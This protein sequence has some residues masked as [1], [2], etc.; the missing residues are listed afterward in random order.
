M[1]FTRPK[2]LAKREIPSEEEI[3]ANPAIPDEQL[4][5]D[6]V[7]QPR[8][9]GA[10][11][12]RYE[13]RLLSY[14]RKIAPAASEDA[15]DILQESFTK[16]YEHLPTFE[17][18]PSKF[19]AWIYTIVRNQTMSVLRRKSH[20]P[21]VVPELLEEESLINSLPSEENIVE[22]AIVKDEGNRLL[23]LLNRL[24]PEYRKVLRMRYIEE[25]EYQEIAA[26]LKVPKAT[27]A[28]RIKRGL[29][30][31]KAQIQT[32]KEA[33]EVVKKKVKRGGVKQK[34]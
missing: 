1:K 11:M 27:V 5:H 29:A 3:A 17:E 6:S 26:T 7:T 23:N 13:S 14:I 4:A 34:R 31:L 22:A 30:Q 16:A 2:L 18:R 28:T 20:R 8:F 21:Q 33:P 10:L 12:R 32:K 24:K 9:F 19:S 25:M 15:E